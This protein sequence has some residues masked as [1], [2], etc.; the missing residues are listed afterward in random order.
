MTQ[1]SHYK[2]SVL[3]LSTKLFY[4]PHFEHLLYSKAAATFRQKMYALLSL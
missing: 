3:V 2:S 4:F 1:Q